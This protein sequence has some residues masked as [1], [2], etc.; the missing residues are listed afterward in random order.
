MLFWVSILP[1][2]S[3]GAKKHYENGHVPLPLIASVMTAAAASCLK[4]CKAEA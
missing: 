1:K 4:N 2:L 3:S